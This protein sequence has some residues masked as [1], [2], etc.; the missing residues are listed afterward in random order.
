[1]PAILIVKKDLVMKKSLLLLFIGLLLSACV[2]YAEKRTSS[3]ETVYYE[4]LLHPA[5]TITGYIS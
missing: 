3:G 5:I 4:Y 2:G 1:L